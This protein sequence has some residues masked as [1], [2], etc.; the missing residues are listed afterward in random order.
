MQENE[1][2]NCIE[3]ETGDDSDKCSRCEDKYFLADPKMDKVIKYN[4]KKIIK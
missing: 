4:I 1:I 2:E 3:C